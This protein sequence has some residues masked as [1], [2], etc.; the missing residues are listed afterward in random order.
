MR[1]I[2]E[3]VIMSDRHMS[4]GRMYSDMSVLTLVTNL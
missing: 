3:E 4:D 1:L 2:L